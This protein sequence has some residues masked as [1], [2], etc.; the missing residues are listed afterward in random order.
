MKEREIQL[1]N[2]HS[3][4]KVSI[5]F[6]LLMWIRIQLSTVDPNSKS[7]SGPR[8]TND[9]PGKENNSCLEELDVFS[10]GLEEGLLLYLG[11]PSWMPKRKCIFG[12]IWILNLNL[13]SLFGLKPGCGLRC[14]DFD[15]IKRFFLDDEFRAQELLH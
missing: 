14:S 1:T 11:T 7:G 12:Q 13:F 4:Y 15:A 6:L 9:P 10:R 2:E 8:R 3:I 5:L